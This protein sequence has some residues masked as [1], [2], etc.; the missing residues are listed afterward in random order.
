MKLVT[1][2]VHKEIR[3]KLRE[4]RDKILARTGEQIGFSDIIRF[5]LDNI[6]N[7]VDLIAEKLVNRKKINRNE[8]REQKPI[9]E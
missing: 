7:I 4:I 3:E 2:V 8:T 6:E 9:Y 1:I 5:A